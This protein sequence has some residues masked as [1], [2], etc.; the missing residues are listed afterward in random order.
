MKQVCFLVLCCC[1]VFKSAGQAYTRPTKLLTIIPE[2]T[3]GLN[4]VRVQR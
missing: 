1:F 3:I 2:R 4:G